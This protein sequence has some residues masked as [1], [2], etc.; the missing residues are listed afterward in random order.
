MIPNR[1]RIDLVNKGS[2][3]TFLNKIA[4]LTIW[5]RHERDWH[6]WRIVMIHSSEFVETIA[7]SNPN[8]IESAS[9]SKLACL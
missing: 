1:F 5:H 8:L 4:R 2:Q 3:E 9:T 6:I 7:T